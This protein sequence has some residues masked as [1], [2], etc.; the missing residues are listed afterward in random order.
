MSSGAD[1]LP[2]SIELLW[3]R[4]EPGSRGP[5]RGL[6]LT[7]VVDAAIDLADKE[8]FAALSMA[9]VAEQVGVTT[10]ALYRYVDTKDILIELVSDRVIGP[11]PKIAV[12][13]DWRRGLQQ[14]ATAEY[15]AIKKH[16]WWLDIPLT[17][18]PLGPNNTAWLETAIAVFDETPVSEPVKVQMVLNLSLYVISRARLLREMSAGA[19]A[20]DAYPT[21][22]QSIIDQETFPALT[23]AIEGGAFDTDRQANWEDAD[24][25]WGLERLLDGYERFVN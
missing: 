4:D 2:R 6:T 21:V 8:G 5:K 7:Q 24:L 17:A 12:G 18:P 14:W 23:R 11:P 1:R 3:G 22:L 16:P 13:K 9:R 20:D 25:R 19:D 15:E 10:M